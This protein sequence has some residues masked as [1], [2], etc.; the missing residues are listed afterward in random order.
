MPVGTGAETLSTIPTVPYVVDPETFFQ[1]TPGKN[2]S[3]KSG[4]LPGQGATLPVTLP[5]TGVASKLI[6]QF[7]GTLTIAT[8]AATTSDQWPHNI[9]K[10]F[11]LSANGQ[12]DLFSCDGIDL[13]AL[14]YARYPAYT[15]KVDTFP[16]V[17]G[18]GGSVGVGSYTV[19]VTWEVPIAMDDTTLVGSLF[20]QS[21]Q[22]SVVANITQA[23]NADLFA[24]NPGNATLAGTFY[25]DTTFFEIPTDAH[26]Q[27]VLPDITR[28][29]TFT[30]FDTPY[31][32]TGEVRVPLIRTAGQLER[33]FVSGRVS[34]NLR[35]SGM[36]NAASTK[37]LDRIRLEY[38]GNQRPYVFDPYSMLLSRNNDWFGSVLPYD[39]AALDFVKE[40]PPRDTILMQGVTE[41]AVVQSVG[42]GVTP[43]AGAVTRLVQEALL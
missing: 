36:P 26:G 20:L 27:L 7:V 15:E 18:G 1:Q 28:L 23:Q 10:L 19:C 40:N 29:H 22:V 13:H 31:A 16:D 24:T 33:L 2:I 30:G 37:K 34:T 41:L 14:R 5:K 42:T 12:N 21:D 25:V 43:A 6:V 9:L 38:G 11:R 17:V 3:S 8:A 32:N 39:R 35:L 4:G